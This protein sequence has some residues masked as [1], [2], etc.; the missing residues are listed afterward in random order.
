MERNNLIADECL[1]Y[2]MKQSPKNNSNASIYTKYLNLTF[3][4]TLE[5]INIKF[6][7]S[8]HLIR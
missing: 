3:L 7:I 8:K 6:K 5:I 4:Q 1:K 2:L